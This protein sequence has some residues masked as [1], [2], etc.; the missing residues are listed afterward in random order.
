[1]DK[2]KNIMY[3]IASRTEAAEEVALIRKDV[4]E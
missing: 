3:R 4:E 2:I 1:M